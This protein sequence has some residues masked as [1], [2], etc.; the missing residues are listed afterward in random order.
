[1]VIRSANNSVHTGTTGDSHAVGATIINDQVTRYEGRVGK[2][3]VARHGQ[4]R[5]LIDSR[6]IDKYWT[7]HRHRRVAIEGDA[8]H[9]VNRRM[10]RGPPLQGYVAL[11]SDIAIRPRCYCSAI[12]GN[13]RLWRQRV[14]QWWYGRQVGGVKV[15]QGPQTRVP[16]RGYAVPRAAA[17]CRLHIG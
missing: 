12:I 10:C 7:I 2:T 8:V 1:M 3:G 4:D 11:E 17:D 9:R 6:Q 13:R 15:N 14:G 16:A 5:A